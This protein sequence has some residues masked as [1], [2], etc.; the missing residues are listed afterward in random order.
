VRQGFDRIIG[1][2][3]AKRV[4]TKAVRENKPSHTYLF[5]GPEGT[6]KMAVAVEFAKALNCNNPIDGNPCEECPPCRSIEHHN[7]PE[8]RIWSPEARKQD[9]T[10]DQMREMRDYAMLRPVSTRWKV[11]II[12]QGDTLNEESANCILKLLEE[13][14]G[15]VINI[16]LFRNSANILPTIKSRCRLVRFTQVSA[17]ELIDRLLEDYKLTNDKARFLAVYSQGC[18]GKAIRLIEDEEF[19][20]KRDT[21][22]NTAECAVSG[23]PWSALKLAE[24]LRGEAVKLAQF[25]EDDE[26][27][28]EPID[29]ERPKRSGREGLLE[30]LDILLLWYRD[31]LAT[32]LIGPS[33]TIVNID[34]QGEISAQSMCYP[35]TRRLFD[36]VE[37]ILEAK[38]FVLANCNAQ[39]VTEALMMRL[40][41]C[42]E[43]D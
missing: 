26:E 39:I 40:V 36:A 4:L 24:V 1:Q 31:L 28:N 16:L 3:L 32:K 29:Q 42:D 19:F 14:P 25:S 35:D 22:I 37:A 34:K 6:G 17:A 41:G 27:P 11:N 5:L 21:V 23:N 15:Y 38:R 9:T 43:T 12:E 13:P 18:P 7:C 10:I 2:D 8:V 30:S 20:Q 33:A